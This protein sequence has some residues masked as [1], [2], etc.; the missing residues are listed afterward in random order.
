M[1]L[2][3][4][5]KRYSPKVITHYLDPDFAGAVWEAVGVLEDIE[6]GKWIPREDY[7]VLDAQ[8]TALHGVVPKWIPVTERL[9]DYNLVVLVTDGVD[10]GMGH[11]YALAEGKY[12]GWEVPFADIEED[13]I[14]HWM[15]L[16][17]LPKVEDL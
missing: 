16:P 15:P 14:S 1:S 12:E 4:R 9:P 5:L 6:D 8:V 10:V 17:E 3:N 7:D 2:L 13:D 11:R